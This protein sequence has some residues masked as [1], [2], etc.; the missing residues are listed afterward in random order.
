MDLA[1]LNE[2]GI[3]LAAVFGVIVFWW[4]GKSARDKNRRLDEEEAR[5]R[6]VAKEALSKE[7]PQAG[8]SGEAGKGTDG[9]I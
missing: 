8:G 4:A 2:I 3:A 6:A 9:K 7:E 5:L 1:T